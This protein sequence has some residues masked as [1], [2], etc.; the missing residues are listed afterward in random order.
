[1]WGIEHIVVMGGYCGGTLKKN[2]PV[3]LHVMGYSPSYPP[4]YHN[5]GT[6]NMVAYS[7]HH[8]WSLAMMT[9]A[10]PTIINLLVIKVSQDLF[11]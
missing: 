2:S 5:I 6:A 3:N 9:R 11:L 8:P 10:T 1:M 4:L 7:T